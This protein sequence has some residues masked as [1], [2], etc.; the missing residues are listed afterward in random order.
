MVC[1]ALLAQ[2]C[3]PAQV[4]YMGSCGKT[5]NLE[6]VS[7][8]M[9]RDPLPEAR[10]I[11]QWRAIIRSDSSDVCQTTLTLTD[12]NSKEAISHAVKTEL[13]L[14]T[15]EVLFYSFDDYRLKGNE[16]CFEVNV[17]ISGNKVALKS[18]RLFCAHTM[19]R[20]WWTMR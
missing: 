16:V 2:A 3:G 8:A 14:G 4:P 11:D 20:G 19:D 18:P 13:T 7:L 9:F 5:P 15:N 1:L 17:Y 10:K 6:L 12:A